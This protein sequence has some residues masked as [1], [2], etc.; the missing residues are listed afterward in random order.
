MVRRRLNAGSDA[1]SVLHLEPKLDTRFSVAETLSFG[2][3]HYGST[4]LPAGVDG[5]Y[6]GVSRVVIPL[7]VAS[8][9]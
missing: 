9:V 6:C 8:Y 2:F 7:F 5:T 4:N 1:V 3:R